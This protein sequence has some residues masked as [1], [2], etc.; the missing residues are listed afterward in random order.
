MSTLKEKVFFILTLIVFFIG[1]IVFLEQSF[2]QKNNMDKQ[3]QKETQ[4]N[5]QAESSLKL[6]TLQQKKALQKDKTPFT[7]KTV[8]TLIACLLFMYMTILG[9][10]LIDKT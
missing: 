1:A 9:F 2:R 4:N 6:K 7:F 3:V 8:A 10:D 5:L